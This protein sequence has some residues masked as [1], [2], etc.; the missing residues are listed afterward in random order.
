LIRRP[1]SVLLFVLGGLMLTC[2]GLSAFFDIEPGLRD[3]LFLIG[4]YSALAT[5]LL[6]LGTW[7]SPGERWRELGLTMLIALGCAAVC[8]VTVLVV[9]TDPAMKGIMPP[10]LPPVGVAAAVGIANSLI[11]GVAGWLLYR[12]GPSTD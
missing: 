1:A 6:L 10:D 7:I 12:Q 5:P 8:V 9:F 4:I 3:S 2:E 11:L